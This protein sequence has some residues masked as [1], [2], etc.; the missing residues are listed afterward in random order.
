MKT[1]VA[2]RKSKKVCGLKASYECGGYPLCDKHY[3]Q[4]KKG[5]TVKTRLHGCM[6]KI[7]CE[8]M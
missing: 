1:C 6:D 5:K 7:R 8:K 2:L 4:Y 3:E